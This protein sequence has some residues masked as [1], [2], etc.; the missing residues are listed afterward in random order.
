MDAVLLA[1][2]QFSLTIGFHFIFP[3]VTIGM[4]WLIFWFT[5]KYRKTEDES[6]GL[7]ARFWTKNGLNRL[8]G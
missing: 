2:I 7:A 3:P 1:R 6:V 4:A 5:N 8:T